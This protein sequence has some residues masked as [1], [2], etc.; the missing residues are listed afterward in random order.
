MLGLP[1]DWM[2]QNA[3]GIQ[4]LGRG[5]SQLSAGQ[6][7]D[8]SP[9]YA[10]LQARQQNAA[11]R[12]ALQGQMGMFTPEQRAILATMPPQLAQSIIA[13]YAFAPPADPYAHLMEVGG[14]IYDPKTREW[15][16]PPAGMAGGTPPTSYR[17]YALTD[18][19]PT[20]EEYSAWLDRGSAGAG[21]EMRKLA[22]GRYYYVPKQP[23][24]GAEPVLVAPDIQAPPK[25]L[26][27][28]Q[29][30]LRLF[31]G[32][33]KFTSPTINRIEREGFDP[34]NIAER[35]AAGGRIGQNFF[36]SDEGQ[37]YTAAAR[38]WAEGALRLATGAAA[39]DAEVSRNMVTFFAQLG[40]SPET[41]RY[42]RGVRGAYEALIQ[43]LIDEDPNAYIPTP[44]QFLAAEEAASLPPELATPPAQEAPQAE[45]EAT[46][47]EAGA[48]PP[49]PVSAEEQ[50]GWARAL[51]LPQISL[52][53]KFDISSLA[54]E[55]FAAM[56]EEQRQAV[57]KR[58]E[59]LGL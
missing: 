13:K 4:A 6:A 39:P 56:T 14:S 47:P 10:Q 1:T 17:E 51:T 15:I 38:T 26:T 2:Q 59:E 48:P 5:L 23:T 33:Q 49:P 57:I 53:S 58:A 46:P 27:E 3:L 44:E 52:L 20:P 55:A 31:G 37:K 22:D 32:M 54:D 34:A 35:F 28:M 30:R 43:S 9:A 42:K 21:M 24:P 19:T 12:K 45:M 50:V 18:P 7:P 25:P 29:Q 8:L 16:Q 36:A 11:M 41:I 40:D